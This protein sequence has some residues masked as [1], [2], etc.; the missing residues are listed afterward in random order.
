MVRVVTS[1][2]VKEELLAPPEAMMPQSTLLLMMV[3]YRIASVSVL[4]L[5]LWW[6]S[7]LNIFFFFRQL[8]MT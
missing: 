2:F 4:G 7:R 1:F 8:L 6:M 3:F 5:Y